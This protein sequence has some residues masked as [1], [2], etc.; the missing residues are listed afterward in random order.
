MARGVFGESDVAYPLA[1]PRPTCRIAV[2]RVLAS[3]TPFNAISVHAD[4]MNPIELP[5]GKLA[6]DAAGTIV[7]WQSLA[8][9][10]SDVAVVFRRLI[11]LS[12]I[13]SRLNRLSGKALSDVQLDRLAYLVFLHDLGK[14]NIGFQARVDQSRPPVGH[15]APLS[16]LFGTSPIRSFA[17]RVI[18]AL[19]GARLESW[20]SPS[21]EL[22]D[23]I[24]SHHGAPWPRDEVGERFRSHWVDT[25]LYSCWSG[26]SGLV[27][28]ADSMFPE[29]DDP[30][31]PLP[32][33]PRFIHAIAGLVQIA[34]W[35]GSA[36][37]TTERNNA[38]SIGWERG[39][40]DLIGIDPAT[41]RER[42]SSPT[43]TELFKRA[44]YPHQSATGAAAGRLLILESETGS[45]KTEAALWRFLRLFSDGSVDGLYFALPT[46]T[47]AVQLHRRVEEFA[48][49]VWGNESPDVVLA[50]P[51][52]LHTAGQGALPSATDL[53]DAPEGDTRQ[54]SGWA[55]AHPKRYF[56]A[57]LAVGTIDQ[58]LL[59]TLCV[60][61]AH[62]RGSMLMRHLLVVDEVHASDAYMQTL[63]RQLLEDHVAAGGYAVLLSAT[64]GGAARARLLAAASGRRLEVADLPSLED[65]TSM[66]YPLLSGD[67]SRHSGAET[68]SRRSH[69][70]RMEV[71]PLID[72]AAAIAALAAESARGGAKVL[73]VRNSV[74]GA[75]DVFNAL[76]QS[77]VDDG[78]LLLRV[79]ET[80][81]VHHGRFAR[82]DRVRL[83]AAVERAVGR[84]RASGGVVVVGTQTLE[85]SLDIDADL[86]ITDLCPADVL[87]QRLGRLHRHTEEA[88]GST[89][90]RPTA[91]VHPLALVLAPHDGLAIYLA[92]RMGGR[93]RHGLGYT[94]IAGQLVGTYRDLVVLEATRR[95]IAEYPVWQVPEMNRLVVERALHS[96]STTM[97]LEE[98]GADTGSRWLEHARRLEGDLYAMQTSASLA[99]L[100]RSRPFME[101]PVRSDEHL[102]TRL[103]ADSRI[104]DLPTGTRGCFGLPVSSIAVP[105]WMLAVEDRDAEPVIGSLSE[106]GFTLTLGSSQLRYDIRG[107]QQVTNG[108]AL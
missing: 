17:K 25:T 102:T 27:R 8:G 97:L 4:P 33:N 3:P 5:W 66:V 74:R 65:A 59:S 71:V 7:G 80:S 29:V 20:G 85:Q 41:W 83:D 40:L 79:G 68:P 54:F 38:G 37:W 94:D 58:A 75:I 23:V 90:K 43:F 89:R 63:L 32:D 48:R 88:D 24:F 82:E 31:P 99:L 103:G 11:G 70:T 15:I 49:S 46:R 56:T 18:S 10:S 61:H 108:E 62:L 100:R 36:S 81:A 34:D 77:E 73:I 93:N 2:A 55:N 60:K 95:L 1:D 64:L 84:T 12:G 52:Y 101:Q 50:V 9:H 104:V 76:R 6:R 35:I 53:L 45:G 87:L 22:L 13:R 91:H 44:P 72:D 86:L 30:S 26:L 39:A 69:E 47:A 28:V 98:L 42:I 51:G 107:L 57:L 67:E 14:V 16:A 19:N 105:G 21:S 106:P 78:P 96:T 92:K